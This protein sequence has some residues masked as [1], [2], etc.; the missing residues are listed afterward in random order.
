MNNLPKIYIIHYAKLV[1]R[2]KYLENELQKY[3]ITNFEFITSYQRETTDVRTLNSLI[4]CTHMTNVQKLVT[5]AHFDT[6]KKIINNSDN[7]AIILE[8]DTILCDNFLEK[9]NA[10]YEQLPKDYE[11]AILCDAFNMHPAGINS[12]QIWYRGNACKNTSAYLIKKI[13][14][15]NDLLL[16]Y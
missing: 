12:N 4:N 7:E 11:I 8:D 15:F 3:G 5:F 6:Y 9:F 16:L 13:W 2:R 14:S 10:Y 1:D